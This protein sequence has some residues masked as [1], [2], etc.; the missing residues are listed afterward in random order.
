MT[1]VHSGAVFFKTAIDTM[2]LI[3]LP[4]SNRKCCL[5]KYI[6]I[7]YNA[8]TSANFGLMTLINYKSWHIT[9]RK[10]LPSHIQLLL[11]TSL[12]V[13]YSDNM[14]IIYNISKAIIN[15]KQHCIGIKFKKCLFVPNLQHALSQ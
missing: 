5:S 7:S 6:H 13:V 4:L 12:L 8:S 10:Q 15:F 9:N 3:F 1:Q 14:K 2:M 11:N